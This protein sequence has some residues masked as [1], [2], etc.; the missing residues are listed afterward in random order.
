[1]TGAR[2][3]TALAG[4]P[5]EARERKAST[6]GR[7]RE[8]VA[9]VRGRCGTWVLGSLVGGDGVTRV[10]TGAVPTRGTTSGGLIRGVAVAVRDGSLAV[11]VPDGSV[12]AALPAGG[13]TSIGI[14]AAGAAV[15]AR[16]GAATGAGAAG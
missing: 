14:G 9:P 4:R 12:A 11:A 10:A 13:T 5:S 7:L 3:R 8:W 2:R 6:G 1:M 16:D 15:A